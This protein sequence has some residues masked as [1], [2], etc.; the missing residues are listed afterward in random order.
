MFQE[1]APA[2][3]AMAGNGGM[4]AAP[5]MDLSETDDT[6]EITAEL[7][8]VDL[9]DLDVSVEGDMLTLKGEKKAE[10]E[11]KKKDYHF[12]ERSY[13]SFRRAIRLPGTVDPE[14][15]NATFDKGVLKI[16]MPKPEEAKQKR[17]RIE[18]KSA[19]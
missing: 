16:T 6:I 9:K 12:V 7:P 3:P 4:V 2:L 5:R 11:E 17:R 14:K 18:V 13:G 19:S 1:F 8:G 15:V 10:T